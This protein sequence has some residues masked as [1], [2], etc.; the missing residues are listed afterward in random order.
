MEPNE[1][2]EECELEMEEAIEATQRELAKLRTGRASPS[3][4]D[5]VV[6]DAYG[7]KTPLKQLA[8]ISIP[9]A[10]LIVIHPWDKSVISEIEKAIQVADLGI[11]PNSDGQLIRLSIPPLTEERRREQVKLAKKI[12]EEGKIR[13]RHIRRNSNESLKKAE[14]EG[15]IPEDQSHNLQDEVQKLT[16]KY[17]TQIDTLLK[18]KENDIMNI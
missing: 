6:V 4:L 1:Y 14:K 10:R 9:E 11:N 12:G 2:I 3:L 8:N 17:T 18:D 5:S 15:S 7:T 16:D 13:I